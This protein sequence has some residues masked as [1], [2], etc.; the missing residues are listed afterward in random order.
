MGFSFEQH[1]EVLV[2]PRRLRWPFSWTG[3]IPFA[4]HLVKLLRPRVIVE[5]GV[6]TGNSFS[7]FCQGVQLAKTQTE[8]FGVDTWQGDEHAGFYESSIYNDLNRDIQEHYSGFAKLMRMS[9]DEALGS[10]ADGS[11]DLLHI[12]GLH[13]YDAVTHDFVTWLPKLSP[14]AVVLFH[15]TSVTY[16][17][18]GVW[19]LWDEVKAQYPAAELRHS[20]GLGVAAVGKSVPLEVLSLLESIRTNPVYEK[21]F[22][23]LG[24]PLRLVGEVEEA[25]RQAS[26]LEQL[27]ERVKK[28]EK[29]AADHGLDTVHV[30]ELTVDSGFGFVD[31]QTAKVD[32]GADERRLQFDLRSIRGENPGTARFRPV[33]CQAAVRILKIEVLDES[34][35]SH[36]IFDYTSNKLFEEDGVLIFD[37]EQPE[38]LFDLSAIRE[39]ARVR[40][41]LEYVA[42]GAALK[43]MLLARLHRA[44]QECGLIYS[45]ATGRIF[46]TP[47]FTEYLSTDESA[48]G[49]KPGSGRSRSYDEKLLAA[50][51]SLHR[52]LRAKDAIIQQ[53]TAEL[54]EQQKLLAENGVA[55]R[56]IPEESP[57]EL[58]A[59]LKHRLLEEKSRF[60]DVVN[61]KNRLFKELEDYHLQI[62][63]E[64]DRQIAGMELELAQ[65]R[66]RAEPREDEESQREMPASWKRKAQQSSTGQTGRK[67]E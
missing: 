56:R 9:F 24:A 59:D 32:I 25:K 55:V 31:E 2:E 64:R 63:G 54:R 26:E 30:A 38:I 21:T 14:R 1:P 19:K 12:D 61:E 46:L 20:F 65:L 37:E 28:I 29:V 23:R 41:Y 57:V 43:E 39:P 17:D 52:E 27:R 3:H 4:F 67:G 62:V 13:T 50:A 58:I 42:F 51:M 16:D 8:C 36:L 5:L 18:F 11:I 35:E 60:H 7:A 10:F 33:N 15:D 44:I 49:T 40:V 34:E 45:D 47:Q 53:K 22:E 66:R 48:A 6:H